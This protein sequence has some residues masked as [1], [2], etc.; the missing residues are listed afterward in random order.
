MKEFPNK[1]WKRRAV[2]HLI[3]KIDT[4]QIQIQEFQ[5]RL[6]ESAVVPAAAEDSP[7]STMFSVL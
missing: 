4:F 6:C 3:K 1:M 7:L 5:I 2:D